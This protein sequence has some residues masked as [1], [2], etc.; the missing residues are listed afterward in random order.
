ML[1]DFFKLKMDVGVLMF[2]GW[3][4]LKLGAYYIS[5]LGG[6]VGKDMKEVGW[7]CDGGQG[8]GAIGVGMWGEM[9]TTQAEVVPGVVG[10]IEVVLYDLV[11]GGNIDLIG[12]VN[13]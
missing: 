7:G 2:G 4:V 10:T 12:I 1:D 13:L 3:E 9:I 5:L 6:D 8:Q 11:S